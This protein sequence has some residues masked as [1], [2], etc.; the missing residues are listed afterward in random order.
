MGLAQFNSIISM[1]VANF[2]MLAEQHSNVKNHSCLLFINV[3]MRYYT[4][5]SFSA[6][7]LV[8][9]TRT[10]NRVLLISLFSAMTMDC[11]WLE[12]LFFSVVSDCNSQC[13]VWLQ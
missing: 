9:L 11:T 3:I 4:V 8:C 2:L 1:N 10:S 13:N 6:G 7:L 12:M 5:F